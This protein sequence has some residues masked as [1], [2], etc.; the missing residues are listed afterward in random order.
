MTN[1]HDDE[2]PM[3]CDRRMAIFVYW[4]IVWLGSVMGRYHSDGYRELVET[5]M[6]WVF[7]RAGTLVYFSELQ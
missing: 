1:S 3:V 4:L 2:A 5:R 6:A 7:G